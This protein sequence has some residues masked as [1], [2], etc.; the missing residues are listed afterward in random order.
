M[1]GPG[2]DV[3]RTADLIKIDGRG[4]NCQEEV[5]YIPNPSYS[6]LLHSGWLRKKI[7]V[8]L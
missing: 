1:R 4:R 5:W 3:A 6:G 2:A 7:Y 8:V